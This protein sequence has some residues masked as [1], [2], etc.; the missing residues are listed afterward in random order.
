MKTII[1]GPNGQMGRYIT[2]CV[3]QTDGLIPYAGVGRKGAAYIGKDLG[4]VAML[5][6]TIGVPVVDNLEDVIENADVIIDFSTR[7]TSLEVLALAVKYKTPLVCGTT[8]FSEC[9][10]EKFYQAAMT[11]PLLYAANTSKLVNIMKE[12]LRVV[13]ETLKE[14]TDIEIVEMH[15][16]NKKDAP[17][18]TAKDLGEV[19]AGALKKE[20]N[21]IARY[22]KEGISPREEGSLRFHSMRMGNVAS[23]HSVYFGC[24]GE[25]LEI[26][27]HAYSFECFARGACDCAL[28]LKGK[29]PGY[30]TIADALQLGST[31]V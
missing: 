17:S 18:G 10:K 21:D 29:N 2:A 25:R 26:T 15:D 6:E 9:E 30:Y 31:D 20:L 24:L 14:E 8:G 3:K 4:T 22:E 23:S 1:I 11:I 12:L 28:F 19:I 16:R 5:G 13:T 7:E 27:H